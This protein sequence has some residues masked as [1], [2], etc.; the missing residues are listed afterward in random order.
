MGKF[1]Q[2]KNNPDS[3]KQN[4]GKMVLISECGACMGYPKGIKYVEDFS[5]K[6]E[7]KGVMC[8]KDKD[9]G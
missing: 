2:S 3:R 4:K 6:K 7:G 9:V 1:K 5:I 8:Y